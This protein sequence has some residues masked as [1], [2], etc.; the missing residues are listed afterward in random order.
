MPSFERAVAVDGANGLELDLCVTRDRE[1]VLWHD[2]S[3]HE[4]NA[5]FRRWGLEPDVRYRPRVPSDSR[6]RKPVHELTL[7]DFRSHYGYAEK[8]RG[9]ARVDAAIP[10]LASFLEW[11][12]TKRELGIV[13]FDI[14]IPAE[15]VGLLPALLERV[16]ALVAQ[17]SPKFRIV[18]ECAAP[19]V[20]TELMRLAPHFQHTLDV[21]PPAGAVFR[22]ERWSA[23]R[24]AIRHGF[25]HATPQKP[26]SITLWPFRTHRR[27]VAADLA[28]MKAH[29]DKAPAVPLDGVCSFTINTEAEMRSL[30]ALGIGGMQSDRPDLLHRVAV[31]AGRRVRM[32]MP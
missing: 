20:A 11:A 26:R 30:I 32:P 15:H 3:P 22:S 25:R 23:V 21:E 6:W 8:M 12:V 16:D 1:V 17:L 14:K 10:V 13:F 31:A 5:R 29:N 28:L 19:E 24:E 27:I 7:A 2:F 4:Q 18:L 9:G